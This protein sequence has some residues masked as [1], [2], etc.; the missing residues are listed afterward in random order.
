M[1]WSNSYNG[2]SEHL[3][4]LSADPQT[5]VWPWWVCPGQHAGRARSPLPHPG[6]ITIEELGSYVFC[7]ANQID[8]ITCFSKPICHAS[9]LD[10]Q[11]FCL[12]FQTKLKSFYWITA[13]C[14]VLFLLLIMT[15]ESTFV[16]GQ[17]VCFSVRNLG[18][19]GPFLR[20]RLDRIMMAMCYVAINDLFSLMLVHNLCV[21]QRLWSINQ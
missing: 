13:I 6:G 1:T 17:S 18:Q 14:F 21:M 5:T 4:V 19:S 16:K 3:A 8:I 20:H 11:L 15:R 7:N 12:K 10:V 2:N 9:W